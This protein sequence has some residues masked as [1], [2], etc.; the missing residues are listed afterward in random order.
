MNDIIP[1]EDVRTP[2]ASPAV[3]FAIVLS[4]AIAA[5][6]GDPAELRHAV[7]ELARAKLRQE[8]Y[9]RTPPVTLLE[10]RKLNT[11]LETAI[12]RVEA[13]AEKGD[14]LLALRSLNHLITN[15]AKGSDAS[16]SEI[17]DVTPSASRTVSFRARTMSMFRGFGHL[18]PAVVRPS[19]FILAGVVL[20][21]IAARF[22]GSL[23]PRG[24]VPATAIDQTASL[25]SGPARKARVH[26]EPAA[27]S[28]L[29][30]N[31]APIPT[32]YGIYAASG[33]K[34]FELDAL[35]GRAPDQ[36][37]FMSAIITKPSHTILPDRRVSFVAFK[38]EYATA[39]PA[40]PS[41]R[42]V[43]QVMRA[44]TFN[45]KGNVDVTP[46]ADAW[47]IRNIEQPLKI[48]PLENRE[49]LLIGPEGTELELS[50]GRYALVLSGLAYDFSVAG[51]IKDSVHCLERTTAANGVFYSE[52]RKP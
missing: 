29:P 13:H 11:A 6:K 33:G 43:A 42:V 48:S 34:L 35:P 38:R 16:G 28:A 30:N 21:A 17:I 4:R 1:T 49:M 22:Q 8:S 5:V 20:I 25:P 24:S 14:E 19:V 12:A 39:V 31:S 50:P 26:S 36:R 41:V 15:D 51:N 7:Y 45:A 40:R 46:V 27:P 10:F 9:H 2:D 47:S 3:D 32:S 44:L 23:F 37:I 52:C 18:G